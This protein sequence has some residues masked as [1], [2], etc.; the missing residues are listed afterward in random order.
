MQTI[1]IL[2]TIRLDLIN[3]ISITSAATIIQEHEQ[4][5]TTSHLFS[6]VD[7]IRVNSPTI[8][9]KPTHILSSNHDY[10]NNKNQNTN[11]IIP[12]VKPIMGKHQYMIDSV[13]SDNHGTTTTFTTTGRTIIKHG[14][15]DVFHMCSFTNETYGY[16][17]ISLK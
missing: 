9:A 11:D 13:I 2:M 14:D 5:I 1:I 6:T 4:V 3:H 12:I 7:E 8:F 16:Y 15:T 17:N 10:N